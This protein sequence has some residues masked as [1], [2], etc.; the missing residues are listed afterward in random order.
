MAYTVMEAYDVLGLNA[1]NAVEQYQI[2]AAD[3]EPFLGKALF[4]SVYRD[5]IKLMY[6]K[7]SKSVPI[8][9]KRSDYDIPA[10]YRT[11]GTFNTLEM[12]SPLFKESYQIDESLNAKLIEIASSGVMSYVDLINRIFDDVNNLIDGANAAAEKM[13]MSLLTTGKIYAFVNKTSS[14]YTYDYEIDSSHT[15]TLLTTARWNQTSTATPV[16]DIE[17]WQQIITDDGYI[18]PTR[19]ICNSTTH[20]WLSKIDSIKSDMAYLRASSYTPVI[21][22]PMVDSYFISKLGLSIATYDKVY[23]TSVDG[24]STKFIPDGYFILIPEG[25]LG[26]L[27]Y[28]PAPAMADAMALKANNVN[29]AV[30]DSGIVV[31]SYVPDPA[32]IQKNMEVSCLMLPQ[33]T[34][35]DSVFMAKVF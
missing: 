1:R 22:T 28:G 9:L 27:V 15:D 25:T 31:R 23:K 21:T 20:A 24:S 32:L 14:E 34:K 26:N 35:L 8:T 19:A 4:P 18:K 33:P 13:I 16:T 11:R 7:G 30:L 5:E 2:T 10:E 17:G 3:K 6:M 12:S 29:Y